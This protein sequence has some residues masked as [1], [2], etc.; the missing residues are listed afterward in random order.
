MGV[1]GDPFWS[2][3]WGAE[4]RKPVQKTVEVPR[5]REPEEDPGPDP[6]P[7]EDRAQEGDPPSE[8]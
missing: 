4:P 6:E 2:W 8:S 3:G 7:G 1:V 5:R